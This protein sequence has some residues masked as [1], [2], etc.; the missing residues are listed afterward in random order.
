[1]IT[2]V[3]F[4]IAKFGSNPNVNRKMETQVYIPSVE[5][6]RTDTDTC[7]DMDEPQKHHDE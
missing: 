7:N 5:Q 2:T 4:I 1:M 6:K 3:L